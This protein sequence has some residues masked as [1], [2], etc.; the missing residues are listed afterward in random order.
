MSER[1]PASAIPERLEAEF[2]QLRAENTALRAL[3]KEQSEQIA[4]L[5]ERV[6][7]LEARV[8]KDSHNSSKP[9]SSDP[10]F[11]KPAPKSRRQRSGKKA[12][13][14]KDHPGATRAL[15]E[16]PE[17]TIVV[18]LAGVCRCGRDCGE[19]A[20]E[21]LPERRQV[22]ELVVRREVTEY[23]TVEGLCACGETHRS[24]FPEAVSAPVQ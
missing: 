16:N 3:V 24:A 5:S 17:Q 19:I 6:R 7:E 11:K 9:P 15:V 23:R 2:A 10:P 4:R 8:A 21:V 18:P 12:G 22:I 13:G 20:A 1:S 14:Q